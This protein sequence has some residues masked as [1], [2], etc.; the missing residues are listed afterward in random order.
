MK[1]LLT[2]HLIAAV[3]LIGPLVAGG[4]MGL[5]AARTGD[6]TGL[7][8]ATRLVTVYGWASLLVLVF[9]AAMVR[10]EDSGWHISFSDT[11]VPLSLALFV[12]ATGLV[13]GVL[14]PALRDAGRKAEAGEV[15]TALVPRIAAVG[16]VV[17]VLYLVIT[18][19]MVYRP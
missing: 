16:G 7:R 9:G 15:T 12:A 3:F 1:I 19:L 10:G 6:T 14:V 8:T 17:S 2:L 13:L 4:N 11:W 18:V 5:R